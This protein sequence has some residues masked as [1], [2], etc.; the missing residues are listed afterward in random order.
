[1]SDCLFCKIVAGEIP[2]TKVYEDDRVL[3]FMDINPA[4]RGHLLVI[5]KEHTESIVDVSPDTMPHIFSAVRRLGAAAEKKLGAQGFNIIVNKGSAAGQIIFHT[6]VHMIPRY[7]GD[8]L[9]HWPKI[10]TTEEEIAELA[11]A[12]KSG[13]Q[14]PGSFRYAGPIT[15]TINL[16]AVALRAGKKIE[17]DS[18]SMTITNDESANKF[19]TREYRE[20]WEM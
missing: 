4:S 10:D 14:S 17:Y 11:E 1:M 20:G 18:A 15:E 16:G 19:L 8:G 6:H 7:D 5:P 3:A 13:Q 2:S 9:S 12:I